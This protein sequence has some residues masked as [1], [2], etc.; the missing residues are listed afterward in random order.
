M[1][2]AFITSSAIGILPCKW[3]GWK[4]D[5]TVTKKLK[6]LYNSMSENQ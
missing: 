4:S 1:D 3:N 2:E 6:N 5:F